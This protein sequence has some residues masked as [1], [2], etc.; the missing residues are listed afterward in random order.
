[1]LFSVFDEVP[2]PALQGEVGGVDRHLILFIDLLGG[3]QLEEV[4]VAA[5]VLVV[6]PDVAESHLHLLLVQL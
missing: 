6:E 5:E 2:E 3:R 4:V 1:M